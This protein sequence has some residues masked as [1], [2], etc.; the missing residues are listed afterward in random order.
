M[1]LRIQ[2]RL[3]SEVLKCGENRIWFDPKALEDISTAST[4]EDIRELIEKGLIKRKAVKGVCRVRIKR[5]KLRKRKGRRLG[6]GSRKGKKTARMP[7]KRLWIIRIRAIRRRL[8]ELR[9]SKQI[10]KKTYRMLYRK[11]KGGEFRNVAHLNAFVEEIK[12]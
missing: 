8:R 2:R 4:K 6:H 7:R 10:D 9:D 11:A 12:R 5:I 1:D 3:A